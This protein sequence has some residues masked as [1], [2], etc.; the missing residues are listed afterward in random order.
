MCPSKHALAQQG[1]GGGVG[2]IL[3]MHGW[4]RSN[5]A[6]TPKVTS[7]V[8]RRMRAESCP[9]S[10]GH[11]A[12]DTRRIKKGCTRFRVPHHGALDEHCPQARSRGL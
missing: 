1:D 7:L 9:I 11:R 10:R 5:I 12:R 3:L 6:V 2:T 4:P 8:I